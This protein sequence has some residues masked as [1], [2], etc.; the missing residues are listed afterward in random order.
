MS[1]TLTQGANDDKLLDD[2]H[3][4]SDEAEGQAMD[5]GAVYNGGV[6]PPPA[7]YPGAS[8]FVFAVNHVYEWEHEQED[9]EDDIE[10]DNIPIP[11]S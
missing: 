10:P 5:V 4:V 9:I 8:P 3:D 11:E 6:P 1:A 7:P 2:C